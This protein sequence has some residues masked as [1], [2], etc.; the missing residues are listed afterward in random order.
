[1]RKKIIEISF[2]M[3]KIK[4]FS[5]RKPLTFSRVLSIARLCF[6]WIIFGSIMRW[7][8][9]SIESEKKYN[10]IRHFYTLSL[11][12]ILK[13]QVVCIRMLLKSSF[14]LLESA[15]KHISG[16]TLMTQSSSNS[17]TKLSAFEKP[18][19]RLRVYD[20]SDVNTHE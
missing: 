12:N 5:K 10:E 14:A 15:V 16:I 19:T 20:D 18:S 8:L 3:R 6:A 4:T 17:L 7:S 13:S 1:M 2:R 9:K 11:K